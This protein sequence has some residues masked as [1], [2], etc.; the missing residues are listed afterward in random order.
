MGNK[1]VTFDQDIDR[2]LLKSTKAKV[3]SYGVRYEGLKYTFAGFEDYI[4]RVISIRED[5]GKLL[6]FDSTNRYI[7]T[8]QEDS[9]CFWNGFAYYLKISYYSGMSAL[10]TLSEYLLTELDDKDL[11]EKTIAELFTICTDISN[12]MD[13]EKGEKDILAAAFEMMELFK[14]LEK[15]LSTAP[16]IVKGLS[17]KT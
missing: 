7:G 15:V 10:G 13:T 1:K 5:N 16:E 4:D 6:A 11:D 3:R 17:E 12:A 14:R 9:V 8:L 2:L